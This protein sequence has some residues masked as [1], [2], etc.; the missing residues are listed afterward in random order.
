MQPAD[1]L[2]VLPSRST[3]RELNLLDSLALAFGGLQ[4]WATIALALHVVGTCLL[5]VLLGSTGSFSSSELA[6]ARIATFL[7]VACFVPYPYFF[8][9][10]RSAIS[11]YTKE[12]NTG[13]QELVTALAVVFC[14]A[15]LLLADSEFA[16]LTLKNLD[17]VTTGVIV[18]L[19][20]LTSRYGLLG[21]L[22]SLVGM[23]SSLASQVVT[24]LT[25]A[26]A[27]LALFSVLSA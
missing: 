3:Q 16:V 15:L 4:A 13:S 2:G 17:V 26:A 20:P 22:D 19:A 10:Y 11:K 25:L 21:W 23:R 12:R 9:V 1:R 14:L 18:L 27:A 8:G 24:S 5:L 7:A 6:P